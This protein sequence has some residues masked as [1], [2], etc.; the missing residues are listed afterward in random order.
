MAVCVGCELEVRAPENTARRAL[1]ELKA[2]LRKLKRLAGARPVPKLRCVLPLDESL[3]EQGFEVTQTPGGKLTEVVLAGGDAEGLQYAVFY[4]QKEVLDEDPAEYWTLREPRYP[5][6]F[7]K[8]TVHCRRPTPQCKVRTY[9]DNDHEEL[10]HFRSKR[11]TI[12]WPVWQQLIPTLHKLGYNCIDFYDSQGRA[13]YFIFEHYKRFGYRTDLPL[14]DRV[15][16]ALHERGMRVQVW[17]QA[18]E[19]YRL[20]RSEAHWKGNEQKWIEMWRYFLK[21]TPFGKADYF[22]LWPRDIIYDANYVLV[23]PEEK[24]MGVPAVTAEF[25]T[26]LHEEIKAHN[27]AAQLIVTLYGK[28]RVIWEDKKFKLPADVVLNWTDQGYGQVSQWPSTTRGHAFGMWT[29]AGYWTDHYVNFPFPDKI[30]TLVEEIRQHGFTHHHMICGQSFRSAFHNLCFYGDKLLWNPDATVKE[31]VA[32]WTGFYGGKQSALLAGAIKKLQEVNEAT[33]PFPAEGMDCYGYVKLILERVRPLMGYLLNAP[34]PYPPPYPDWL[35]VIAQDTVPVKMLEKNLLY[36]NWERLSPMVRE[37]RTLLRKAEQAE[38]TASAFL[39]QAA[40]RDRAFARDYVWFNAYL[41][42]LT[43][44]LDYAL[45][46][47]TA[48]C[49]NRKSMPPATKL[50]EPAA[51]A[52]ALMEELWTACDKGSGVDRWKTWWKRKYQRVFGEIPSRAEIKAFKQKFGGDCVRTGYRF[53]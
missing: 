22:M 19:F 33:H 46:R 18:W 20:K 10:A 5:V 1:H 50:A 21:E 7:H 4:F 16:D 53:R 14:L 23:T 3:G 2:S 49:W 36:R 45:A 48:A 29:H 40:P 12:E 13:E 24:R 25:L 51:E 17:M 9:F 38:A 47:M 31:M 28:G 39:E 44:Q 52:I 35:E 41:F 32:R 30:H 6:G 42:R 43:A 26:A 11:M 34:A 8:R 27:P 37:S 15:F